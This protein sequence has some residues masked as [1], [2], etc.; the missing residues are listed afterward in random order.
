M[1]NTWERMTKDAKENYTY[2]Q[3]VSKQKKF[4]D[5][6]VS[7]EQV[8]EFNI[9]KLF[10]AQELSTMKKSNKTGILTIKKNGRIYKVD[11]KLLKNVLNY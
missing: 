9:Y 10:T 5:K 4:K 2:K 1:K 7:K 6:C 8:N 11:S 3:Y